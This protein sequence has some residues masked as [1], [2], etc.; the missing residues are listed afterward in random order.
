MHSYK[1]GLNVFPKVQY[2]SG[3]S[4]DRITRELQ[5]GRGEEAGNR[6]RGLR[7]P[8]ESRR[9]GDSHVRWLQRQP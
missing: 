2:F 8:R 9:N 3:R 4:G 7:A 5:Q 6:G 1:D